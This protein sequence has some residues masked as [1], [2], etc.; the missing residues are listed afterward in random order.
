[1]R[2]NKLITRDM[3]IGIDEVTYKIVDIIPDMKTRSYMTLI[4]EVAL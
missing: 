4:C 2:M 3:R 1:M